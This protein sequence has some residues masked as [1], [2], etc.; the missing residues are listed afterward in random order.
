MTLSFECLPFDTI[1]EYGHHEATKHKY[2]R[3]RAEGRDLGAKAY[4]EWFSQY[5]VPFYHHRWVQ[6]L[7]GKRFFPEFNQPD[8]FGRF[9]VHADGCLFACGE[10]LC[11]RAA[12]FVVQQF[13]LEKQPWELLTFINNRDE[14]VRLGHD[15]DEVR[16]VL[17][18]FGINE[19]RIGWEKFFAVEE[20]RS[21]GDWL[22]DSRQYRLFQPA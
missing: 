7:Y 10:Q 20:C 18:L 8:F 16:K 13:L 12:G 17:V 19:C 5:W 14:I 11:Q 22:S 1:V 4:R 2:L 9:Q 3:S 21:K 15:Y 6:Y